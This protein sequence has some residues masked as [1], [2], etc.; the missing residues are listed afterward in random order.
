MTYF[1][2]DPEDFI[3]DFKQVPLLHLL[4]E[5]EEPSEINYIFLRLGNFPWKKIPDFDPRHPFIDTF[6]VS[7]L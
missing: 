4:S 5:V 3:F 6:M 1:Q 2:T 7:Q